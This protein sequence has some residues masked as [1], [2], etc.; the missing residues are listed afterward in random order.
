M[1]KGHDFK[2]IATLNVTD[3]KSKTTTE[4][5]VGFS[6]TMAYALVDA[7]VR[8]SITRMDLMEGLIC[9]AVIPK[10]EKEVK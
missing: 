1:K 4:I 3:V 9:F 7:M 6:Q 2:V 5:V 8:K 10:D